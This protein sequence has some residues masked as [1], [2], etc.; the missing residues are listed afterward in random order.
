MKLTPAEFVIRQFNGVRATARALG[1]SP[2][3]VSK[4][5]KT[6]E[7]KGTDGQIPRKAMWEIIAKARE[8]GIDLNPNDLLLGRE[9]QE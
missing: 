6:K 8:L 5:T 2:S 7:N 4:W 3:S 9:V 1:R